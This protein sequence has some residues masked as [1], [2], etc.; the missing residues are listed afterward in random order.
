MLK[1]E[2]WFLHENDKGPN[3]KTKVDVFVD[4]SSST[5][6]VKYLQKRLRAIANGLSSEGSFDP[7]TRK[8]KL[9][10]KSNIKLDGITHPFTMY[11]EKNR[12]GIDSINVIVRCPKGKESL[13][14]SK[15]A[16]SM[17][18][19]EIKNAKE[20]ARRR[21]LK[22]FNFE[23]RL[24]S[25]LNPMK[26][27]VKFG[28]YEI[29]PATKRADGTPIPQ[30]S[31]ILVRGGFEF[32]LRFAVRA[33]DDDDAFQIAMLEAKKMAAWLSLIF[34]LD[35]EFK[36]FSGMTK[37]EVEWGVHY[38]EISRPDFRFI[39]RATMEELRIPMDFHELWNALCSLPGDLHNRFMNSCFNYQAALALQTRFP[40]LSYV[41]YI[42]AI[43]IISRRQGRK[44]FSNF[45]C[46]QLGTQATELVNSLKYLYSRR[47]AYLHGHGVGPGRIFG[48]ST[49][50]INEEEAYF[51][52]EL[53]TLEKL[54]NASMISFL[55]KF[56]TII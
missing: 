33:L 13:Q 9:T 4:D 32:K 53:S 51:T 27:T 49:P 1:V 28:K 12:S 19:T 35:I 16:L 50:L 30:K 7:S 44:N 17:L 21:P 45:V 56:R 6:F 42:E 10:M 38:E 22:S 11:L 41:L 31:N 37:D 18:E 47:S 36:L 2:N 5:V 23:A 55:L 25:N 39:Y 46:K 8:H 15:R 24:D 14:L 52:Q 3:L 20:D 34:H 43:N 54:V 40:R 29:A 48:L 26:S